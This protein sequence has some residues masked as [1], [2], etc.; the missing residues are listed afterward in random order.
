MICRIKVLVLLMLLDLTAVYAQTVSGYVF[1]K[2]ENKPLEGAFVYLDGTTVSTS[3]DARGFFRLSIS[4]N[5][6]SVLVVSYVGFSTFRLENPLGYNRPVKIL[7]EE[8]HINLEAVVIKKSQ[9]F[10]RKQMLK[11]FR[12]QF[13]GTSAEASS[14]RIENEDDIRLYYNAAT[15]T[16]HAEAVRPIRIYNKK[17]RYNLQFDLIDFR[18]HYNLKSLEDENVVNSFFAGTTYF[19]DI[20]K[21]DEALKNRSA[22][23]L[24]SAAHL[25]KTIVNNDWEAQKF[26]FFTG[27]FPDNPD[28]YFGVSDTLNLKK[29]T[30]KDLPEDVKKRI[31]ALNQFT[32]KNVEEDTALQKGMVRFN[33]LYDNSKHSFFV[34]NIPSFYIDNDG[35]LLPLSAVTFGGY[36]GGLK[37]G[38]MLPADYSYKQ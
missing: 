12:S 17:L 11:A 9:G 1:D 21:G 38:D 4:Q 30:L 6:N 19:E 18:V 32:G 10:T 33:I 14:C 8:N 34:I 24:G 2:A 5:S 26:R 28:N 29:V 27:S 13:L 36:I 23:Y 7:L 25:L 31:R 37:A 16:L 20:A 35:L 22:A 3:T 15:N